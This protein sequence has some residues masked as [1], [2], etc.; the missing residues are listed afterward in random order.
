MANAV[1]T[2]RTAYY[3]VYKA[4]LTDFTF[5]LEKSKSYKI[6]RDQASEICFQVR[7]VRQKEGTLEVGDWSPT[8]VCHL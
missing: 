2:Q 5:V 4:N 6:G 3:F 8:D 7:T 1:S